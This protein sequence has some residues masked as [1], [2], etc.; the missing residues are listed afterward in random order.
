MAEFPWGKFKA[1]ADGGSVHHE[2]GTGIDLA[3]LNIAIQ[4]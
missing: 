2:S 4:E 1:Y 3:V